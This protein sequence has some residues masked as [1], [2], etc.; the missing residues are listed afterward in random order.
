MSTEERITELEIRLSH[1]ETTID[2]LNATVFEQWQ[3]IDSLTK[4]LLSLKNRMKALT[5]SE[6]DDAPYLP[7]HY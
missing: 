7:P 4:E 5:P 6:I 2:E 1:Q 3:S